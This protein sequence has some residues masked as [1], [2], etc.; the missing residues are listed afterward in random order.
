MFITVHSTV[1]LLRYTFH[2]NALA[3]A[4]AL[5]G[6]FSTSA[7][8]PE[9]FVVDEV[10]SKID[11]FIV[12]KSELDRFYLEQLTNG[13]PQSRELKCQCLAVLIRNKLMMAKAEIDSVV[14]LDAEVDDNTQRR[15]DMILAQ[16]GRAP[17][18]LE[19]VYGK[20]LEQ[21]KAELRDRVKEQMVVSKMES[22]ITEG[23]AVTP[24]EVKRFFNRIPKDSLPYFSASVE[25]AQLVKNAEVSD[26]QKEETRNQLLGI[27][28]RILAGEGFGDLAR[29]YSDDPSVVQNNGDM[30]WVG[31]GQMVPEF[32]ATAFKLKVNEISMPFESDFGFH[33]MQ[34][35]GRRGN[36]YHSQHILISP[37]P[38]AEDVARASAFLDS[39]RTLIVRDSMT[40]E[41]AARE[42]SDDQQTK[43]SGGFFT[44]QDGGFQ[45]PVEELDPV[46]F[47]TIDSM[48]V[49]DV[50]QPMVYRTNEGKDA[51]RI[52]YYKSR[53]APHQA[54]LK[55]DYHRI[56]LAALNEKKN[57]TLQ[58]WFEEAREDVFIDVDREYDFCGILE[59]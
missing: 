9:G 6:V 1:K 51:A 2:R 33:I 39:L 24:A 54:S 23:L 16:S 47:F 11:N 12:L 28:S 17:A 40:F 31:R 13:A 5:F 32:E 37:K 29:K 49:G 48:Q 56:Q 44:G 41:Y 58:T 19:E 52:L 25:V 14:V 8:D 7:Q 38:S 22:T 57:R 36:E 46:V 53:I 21:I 55:D 26:A 35:L 34:L 50:S 42:F 4:L 45:V 15:M 30:G 3:A 10:I 27:R 43:V 20:S 18:E 59:E